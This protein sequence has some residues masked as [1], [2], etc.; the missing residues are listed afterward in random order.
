LRAVLQDAADGAAAACG[1]DS[2][3]GLVWL[4]LL[5]LQGLWGWVCHN[6][7]AW[8]Q[9]QQQQEQQQPARLGGYAGNA[10]LS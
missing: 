3:A 10:A 9:H 2:W 8:Q 6:T 1:D 7:H 4:M 5:L